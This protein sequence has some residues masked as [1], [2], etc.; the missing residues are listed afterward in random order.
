MRLWKS[1]VERDAVRDS[2]MAHL[3]TFRNADW[4]RKQRERAGSHSIFAGR[5]DSRV[6]TH[7]CPRW[8]ETVDELKVPRFGAFSPDGSFLVS[9]S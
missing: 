8:E 2:F 6:V 1:H 5:L 9:L 7:V 4:R 3:W